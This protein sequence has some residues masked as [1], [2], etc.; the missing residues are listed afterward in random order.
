[1]IAYMEFG[2]DDDLAAAL[3]SP[4]MKAAG[5]DL[6]EFATGGT[7]MFTQRLVDVDV[8]VDVDGG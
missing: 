2:S 6:R 5:R 1:M 3:G 7:T 8:D 4:E